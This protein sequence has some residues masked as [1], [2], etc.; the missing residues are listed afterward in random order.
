MKR[1]GWLWHF[2]GISRY[3]TSGYGA[4]GVEHESYRLVFLT[5]WWDH[6]RAFIKGEGCWAD[7]VNPDE[8]GRLLDRA[9]ASRLRVI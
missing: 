1:P 3:H 4:N 8:D 6:F 5:R 7:D 9:F 2:S